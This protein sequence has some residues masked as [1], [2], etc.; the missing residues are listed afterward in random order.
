M[1]D[2]YILDE[3]GN[4]ILE[5]DLDKW[6]KWFHTTNRHVAKTT[7]GKYWISTVF[8]GVNHNFSLYGP[9]VLWETM[10]FNKR[11]VSK[12]EYRDIWMDRCAGTKEQAEA[13]HQQ[14]VKKVKKE[15]GKRRPKEFEP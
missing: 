2:M 13:M 11:K 6:A 7:V 5:P 12:R 3:K 10:V 9:P 4:P 14:M 8:L 15:Y 1:S